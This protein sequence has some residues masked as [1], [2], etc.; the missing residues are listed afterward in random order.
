M[1]QRILLPIVAAFLLSFV[2]GCRLASG[3]IAQQTVAHVET[4]LPEPTKFVVPPE[5]LQAS[6]ESLCDRLAEITTLPGKDPN[7]TDSIYEALVLKGESAYPCLIAKITDTTLTEDPR[8][9]PKWQEYVVG[10]TAVFVLTRIAGGDDGDREES[11]LTKMLPPKYQEEWK[12]NGIYAYFN[13]VS[14]PKNRKEL[15]DWWKKWL[16]KKKN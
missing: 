15:Q 12:T 6:S 7:D 16:K 5:L 13:Y 10:D 8:Q 14:E 11:L 3:E 1:F 2:S 4:P 9:A